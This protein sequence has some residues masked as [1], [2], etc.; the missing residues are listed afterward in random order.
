E[1]GDGT[2]LFEYQFNRKNW[3]VIVKNQEMKP[4][5]YVVFTKKRNNRIQLMLFNDDK[6]QVTT[7]CFLGV[8]TLAPNQ[9]QLSFEEEEI[10]LDVLKCFVDTKNN[11]YIEFLS[12]L[13][14]GYDVELVLPSLVWPKILN[15][16]TNYVELVDAKGN[17]HMVKMDRDFEDSAWSFNGFQWVTFISTVK[18]LN[19]KIIHFKQI[20]IKTFLVNFYTKDG[21]ELDYVF[22]KDHEMKCVVVGCH[23]PRMY[24]VSSGKVCVTAMFSAA[25][26]IIIS[27]DESGGSFVGKVIKGFVA[28]TETKFDSAIGLIA[29]L[30]SIPAGFHCHQM[31]GGYREWQTSYK[32]TNDTSFA[33]SKILTKESADVT[34]TFDGFDE[35]K[36]AYYNGY[37]LACYIELNIV[38][39]EKFSQKRELLRSMLPSESD[40][41]GGRRKKKGVVE[42]IKEKFP[43]DDYGG[44]Q[45]A[46]PHYNNIRV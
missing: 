34:S 9:P 15:A 31:H 32:T 38:Q 7:G 46:I 36:L 3:K 1:A 39:L 30:L 27:S 16:D 29:I 20:D 22:T 13:P 25:K 17:V 12:L 19:P 4:G 2:N 23:D 5:M 8:T 37:P 35:E 24:Q 14:V 10:M 43:G 11:G 45:H 6:T 26:A 33:P 42:K 28:D 18:D 40:G 21:D 41:E 44:K